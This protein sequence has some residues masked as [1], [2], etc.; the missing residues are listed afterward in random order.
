MRVH[1]I[2]CLSWPCDSDGRWRIFLCKCCQARF[3]VCGF[4]SVARFCPTCGVCFDRFVLL[5]V[6]PHFHQPQKPHYFYEKLYVF[7]YRHSWSGEKLE[8]LEFSYT[9]G[10]LS[11][12]WLCTA[13]SA[14]DAAEKLQCVRQWAKDE[15]EDEPCE[16]RVARVHRDDL[17]EFHQKFKLEA[18]LDR[19]YH[20]E[21]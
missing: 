13:R 6:S 12:G 4:E 8:N 15:Y 2:L 16:I 18:V 20:P 11:S 3:E 7:G 14:K 21:G 19:K 17:D 9:G 10:P 1:E 5:Q